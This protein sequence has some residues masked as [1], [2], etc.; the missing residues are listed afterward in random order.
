MD[1][2]GQSYA[3]YVG[4][5][6]PSR[7]P[8]Q[9]STRARKGQPGHVQLWQVSKEESKNMTRYTPTGASSKKGKKGTRG[10]AKGR[11]KAAGSSGRGSKASSRPASSRPLS[12]SGYMKNIRQ[13]KKSAQ[14]A[15][16]K[17]VVTEEDLK[18]SVSDNSRRVDLTVPDIVTNEQINSL[19]SKIKGIEASH[20]RAPSDQPGITKQLDKFERT[21]LDN[22]ENG[23]M[24][25][26]FGAPEKPP[27]SLKPSDEEQDR[28]IAKAT[29]AI[30]DTASKI[31]EHKENI[32]KAKEWNEKDREL[33]EYKMKLEMSKA[34]KAVKRQGGE[35]GEDGGPRSNAGVS[36][37]LLA[38]KDLD[39]EAKRTEERLR[40]TK[41]SIKGRM[42]RPAPWDTSV[43]FHTDG[44]VVPLEK[45][46]SREGPVAENITKPW[47]DPL[48][49]LDPAKQK[50][51]YQTV[52][53][54][55]YGSFWDDP[56]AREHIRSEVKAREDARAANAARI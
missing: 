44:T 10:K 36:P 26:L 27:Q 9:I 19:T 47:K 1:V 22:A 38:M 14:R 16:S 35:D 24:P 40:R 53:K 46:N 39:L 18:P 50:A 32:L 52:N 56:V 5:K 21:Q 12:E 43:A 20:K 41:G 29:D 37:E 17:G 8:K 2:V 45:K 15:R 25:L 31:Q 28:L 30:K 55:S 11:K 48:K 33:W 13:T 7:S 54:T 49:L 3:S 4:D 23:A 34:V 6:H 42:P 51:N